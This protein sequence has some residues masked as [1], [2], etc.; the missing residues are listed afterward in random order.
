[1]NILKASSS[2]MGLLA[3][4]LLAIPAFAKP[5]DAPPQNY[6]NWGVCPFECCTYR[7]WTAE[8]DIPVHQRRSEDSPVLFHVSQGEAL[9]GVDGVVVTERPGVITVDRAVRDGYLRGQE[10][11]QLSLQPGDVLYMLTPLGEGW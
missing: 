8:G 10:Q 11:P 2:L 9:D 7:Q 3:G 6:E 4:V 1:M 5:Q